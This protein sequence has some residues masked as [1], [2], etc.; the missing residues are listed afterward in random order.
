M[1]FEQAFELLL[2]HEGEL[3][4]DPNDPGGLTKW[5]ISQRSYP[6]VDIRNLTMDDAKA[7]YRRDFWNVNL[8]NRL[9]AWCRFDLFDASVHS[10][11]NQA[12]KWLQFAVGELQDGHIGPRTIDAA[13]Q[14]EH[15]YAALL[16]FN[17]AR[18]LFMSKRK[19]WNHHGK[20]WAI[21]MAKNLY[22]GG[23]IGR[24]S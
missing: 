19:N 23:K 5:G 11:P 12:M 18:L 20:G 1:D 14:I 8:S 17:A 16:R 4:D 13:H 15:P 3:A 6:D 24:S 2:G 10:G 21:R 22:R 7:I 9:P